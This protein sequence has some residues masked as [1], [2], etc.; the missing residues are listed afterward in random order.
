[1]PAFGIFS[2]NGSFFVRF[3]HFFHHASLRRFHGFIPFDNNDSTF[4]SG[5]CYETVNILL[6]AE[7]FLNNALHLPY[8]HKKAPRTPAESLRPGGVH[9]LSDLIG[10]KRQLI[11]EGCQD[12]L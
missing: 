3:H 9:V 1:M 5:I 11:S 4:S 10:Q 7:I 6:S 8:A 2:L 12:P